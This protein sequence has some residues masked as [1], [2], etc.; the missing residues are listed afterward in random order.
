MRRLMLA[1]ALFPGLAAAAE[2]GPGE[3]LAAALAAATPGEVVR[4]KAGL[5]F[6]PLVVDKPVVLEGA[7]GAVIDGRGEGTVIKVT[8]A[9]VTVRGLEV[10][11]SGLSLPDMHAAVF[12]DRTAHR[13]VVERNRLIGN[14]FGV[15]VWGPQAAVV[16]GNVIIGRADLRMSER[17]DGIS[18][19]NS[20]GSQIVGNDISLGR[21]GIFTQ[22]SKQNRFADNRFRDLRF[23]VHYMYT[24]DSEVSGN[25]AENVAVG[26]ALMYSSRLVVRGNVALGTRDHG[27][28]LN[29]ANDSLIEDNLVRR[30]QGKCVFIYNANKNRFVGNVFDDCQ[31]GIHF[32]AGSE[33]N[34][35]TGNAFIGNRIQVKYVGT[36]YLDWSADG[37]GNYWSDNPAFDLNGDGLA[38]AAY[39][40][41]DI[42]DRVVWA[43]PAAKL[44]LN[45]PAVQVVRWAQAQFPAVLPGGVVDSAPLMAPPP[46]A[47]WR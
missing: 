29:Y 22:A 23:A 12:L 20:P 13:A 25:H 7:P 35:M 5:H 44:L 16:R 8:A 10:R 31:I 28:L 38:D 21:D 40:P 42:V 3:N 32:T 33:R 1:A 41:N 24:N 46:L 39:R 34:R 9:G 26:Y 2:V 4:L 6:G 47:A 11:N 36:R 19:W 37:R 30:G 17:G 18:V 15:Y 27:I 43:V 14:L 45:S